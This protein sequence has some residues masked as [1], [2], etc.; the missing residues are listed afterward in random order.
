MVKRHPWLATALASTAFMSGLWAA[1]P[2][3]AAAAP[4]ASREGATDVGEVVVTATRQS[5]ALSKVTEP[6]ATLGGGTAAATSPGTTGAVT[7]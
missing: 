6:P 3:G 7:S 4:A 1:A 5:Q 2:A